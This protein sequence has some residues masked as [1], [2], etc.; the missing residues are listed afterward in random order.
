MKLG[1]CIWITGLPG[2]GKSTIARKLQEQLENLGVKTQILS[3]DM[4]RKFA[5]PKPKYTEEEREIVYG[6]LVFTAKMLVENGVNV[7]IDATGNRRRYRN[8]ARESIR[9]FAEIYLKCPLQIC[10]E[11]EMRRKE[12]YYAPR[13]V[14]K[15]ALRGESKTV[16]G[17]GAPYEESLN[18]ELVL[19]TDKLS[20]EECVKKIIEFLKSQS[21]I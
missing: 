17:L 6:S 9:N 14:Y 18:P 16:P 21:Y 2:S 8:L 12:T 20:P 19:D 4:L 3:S 11:R 10:M 15:K 5:T 13:E 7:I 1:W